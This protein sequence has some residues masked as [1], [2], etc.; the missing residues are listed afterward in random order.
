MDF[1]LTLKELLEL[2]NTTREQIEESII[3]LLQGF[4]F[5]TTSWHTASAPRRVIKAVST[6]IADSFRKGYQIAAAGYGKLARGTW[7]D[8]WVLD[9]FN[10]PRTGATYTLGK[11]RLTDNGGG[12]H[13][14][15]ANQHIVGTEDGTKLFTISGSG[16]LALNGTLSLDV[17]AAKPG[18][19]YN[20]PN[21]SI[22]KVFSGLPTVTVENVALS[23][24]DTW[25]TTPGA[26]KESDA[27]YY[28]RGTAQWGKLAIS[29]PKLALIAH[30]LEAAP[31]LT[32]IRVEDD[33]PHGPGST[34]LVLANA[35]GPATSGEVAAVQ[36]RLDTLRVVGSATLTAVAAQ[37]YNLVIEGEAQVKSAF[38]ASAQ[39]AV[40]EN[41]ARLVEE[42]PLG[43]VLPLAQIIE[44][45]MSPEGMHNVK[46]TG[47]TDDVAIGALSALT[48]TNKLQW[49]AV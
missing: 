47:I 31:T 28:Q 13:T 9:R 27:A 44:E 5:P 33:N 29:T 3:A 8:L 18:A 11:V 25:I 32:K 43:G 19:A 7:L 45:I 49:K 15:N 1:P 21:G 24:N 26:N 42:H 22:K 6:P 38:L 4:G 14:I 41:L 36:A 12:P 40:D 17:K 2:R 34:E 46:L 30:A 23:P 39:A 37:A 35:S 48:I 10:L 20:L 16:T